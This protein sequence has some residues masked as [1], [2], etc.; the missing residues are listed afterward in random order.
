[1]E[2]AGNARRKVAARG[3]R[4]AVTGTIRPGEVTCGYADTADKAEDLR[5]HYENDW[6]YYQVRIHPPEEYADQLQL[7][8]GLAQDRRETMR[9]LEDVT[10]KLRAAVVQMVQDEVLSES[11]AARRAEV[12]R[13]TIRKWLG[14]R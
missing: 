12:D 1:M 5:K 4:F 10:G 14:K 8:A 13:M 9:A 11:E 6:G 2:T 7:I 3:P